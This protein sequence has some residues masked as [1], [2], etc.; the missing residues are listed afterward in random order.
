MEFQRLQQRPEQ[1]EDSL[2]AEGGRGRGGQDSLSSQPRRR[3]QFRS[4]SRNGR[5]LVQGRLS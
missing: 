5:D 2:L 4:L 3:L 1:A